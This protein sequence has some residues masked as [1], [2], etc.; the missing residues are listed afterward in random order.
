MKSSG[1]LKVMWKLFTIKSTYD[2][3]IASLYVFVW[4]L[5]TCEVRSLENC[6]RHENSLAIIISSKID[7]SWY[8]LHCLCY[9]TNLT[10]LLEFWLVGSWNFISISI[11]KYFRF[12]EYVVLI[13][14]YYAQWTV[15]DNFWA[16]MVIIAYQ[17]FCFAN[18]NLLLL[19]LD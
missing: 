1:Q 3:F 6:L 10:Y 5:A 18:A 14:F 4:T 12:R 7:S 15:F 16:Q 19:S 17:H 13:L 9:R 2:E 11:W 8:L